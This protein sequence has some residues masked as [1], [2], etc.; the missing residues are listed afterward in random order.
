MVSN[1]Y[2]VL[3]R[4]FTSKCDECGQS[5]MA[6]HNDANPNTTGR[7]A[8][9]TMLGVLRIK[10]DTMYVCEVMSCVRCASL[11]QKWWLVT[12]SRL[13][14]DTNTHPHSRKPEHRMEHTNANTKITMSGVF[15]A[16]E[17]MS[18]FSEK[19]KVARTTR[20]KIVQVYTLAHEILNWKAKTII[21]SWRKSVF[22]L[23]SR[24]PSS[25]H[26]DT[27]SHTHTLQRNDGNFSFSLN[28]ALRSI[29][30][31]PMIAQKPSRS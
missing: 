20:R 24:P 6:K 11:A 2:V 17:K 28:C 9:K 5:W 22:P 8:K 29:F 4:Y 31:P 13:L 27:H 7:D 15:M 19:K 30:C 26:T 14:T 18:K 3:L 25:R 21:A 16:L 12:H 23:V 10:W 1:V